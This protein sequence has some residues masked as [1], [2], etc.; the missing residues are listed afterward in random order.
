MIIVH[1]LNSGVFIGAYD[2][3]TFIPFL[4]CRPDEYFFIANLQR[5]L[6]IQ[7]GNSKTYIQK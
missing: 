2:T 4:F 7:I 1:I 3:N 5:R 6:K